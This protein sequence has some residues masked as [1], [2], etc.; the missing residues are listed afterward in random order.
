MAIWDICGIKKE[1]LYG[2]FKLQAEKTVCPT[3][4]K[5]GQKWCYL[6]IMLTPVRY[7][8]SFYPVDHKPKSSIVG[9]HC[10]HHCI[11]SHEEALHGSTMTLPA[12]FIR[13]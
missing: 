1:L 12:P 6:I 8:L 10:N 3:W 11:I 4:G 9:T 13:Q 2:A 5:T 7:T